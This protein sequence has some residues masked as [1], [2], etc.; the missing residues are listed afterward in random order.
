MA[1]N[2]KGETQG[3]GGSSEGQDAGGLELKQKPEEA[4]PEAKPAAK[5]A[6]PAP[7]GGASDG[8]DL[9]GVGMFLDDAPEVDVRDVELPPELEEPSFGQLR[10]NAISW[11]IFF[12]AVG[13]F[14]GGCSG[15]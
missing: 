7:K 15:R 2:D 3:N 11:V 9:H 12:L 5:A 13:G 6:K 10:R 14:V 1:D 8:D 4:A